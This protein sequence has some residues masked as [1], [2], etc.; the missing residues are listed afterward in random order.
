MSVVILI[1]YAVRPEGEEKKAVTTGAVLV[2]SPDW[3]CFFPLLWEIICFAV[4]G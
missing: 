3:L 1:N 4:C 2:A